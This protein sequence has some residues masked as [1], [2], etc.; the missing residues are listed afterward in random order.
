LQQFI[1]RY[2]ETL[3]PLRTA[4]D[5]SWFLA[6]RDLNSARGYREY[7]AAFPDGIHREEGELELERREY[8]RAV[9]QG[10]QS[11]YREFLAIYPDS[12]H[13]TAIL[14]ELEMVEVRNAASKEALRAML[15]S[16]E[17]AAAQDQAKKRIEYLD[18]LEAN[19]K[20]TLPGYSDFLATYPDSSH[21][22]DI[23]RAIEELKDGARFDEVRRSNS[24]SAYE[25]FLAEFP[26]SRFRPEAEAMLAFF[27][28][29]Q[30]QSID[31]IERFLELRKATTLLAATQAEYRVA[32]SLL[33]EIVAHRGERAADALML[34]YEEERNPDYP[35][36]AFALSEN[37]DQELKAIRAMSPEKRLV[38]FEVGLYGHTA[39]WNQSWDVH[40]FLASNKDVVQ[41]K[42]RGWTRSKSRHGTYTITV[43]LSLGVDYTKRYVGVTWFN[44]DYRDDT[45][46]WRETFTASAEATVST[47]DGAGSREDIE[48]SFP[49]ILL[50][51]SPGVEFLIGWET[52]GVPDSRFVSRI[53]DVQPR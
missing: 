14:A 26:E 31:T 33:R 30:A 20:N 21:R 18:F 45:S 44:P 4:L 47:G 28:I 34:L 5:Q 1:G 50:R 37:G 10:T 7:L 25:T 51:R 40:W 3:E 13:S 2:P 43:Q 32:C 39:D 36:A 42:I 22:N 24:R 9:A 38:V 53:I 23:E 8:E 29:E 48:F 46:T 6:A 17:S 11:A 12:T 41:P 35:L 52:T 16:L 15:T 27:N 19:D 49:R